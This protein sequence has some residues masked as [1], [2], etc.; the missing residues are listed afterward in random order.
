MAISQATPAAS[1]H[2]TI[3]KDFERSRSTR[4]RSDVRP[5]DQT[6]SSRG[7]PPCARSCQSRV[8]LV[9]GRAARRGSGPLRGGT[10]AW[11]HRSTRRPSR[12]CM[13]R[14]AASRCTSAGSSS[15]R[16]PRVPV[17]TTSGTC[18]SD[19]L[20]AGDLAPLPQAPAAD[21]SRPRGSTSGSPTPSSTSSTTSATARCPK[22]GRVRE[23]LD[24]CSRLHS[25]RLGRERPLWEAHVIEG[26]R[27]GRVALY[28]KIHHGLVD[29]VSAMRLMQ[30]VLSTDPDLRD[31]PPPWGGADRAVPGRRPASEPT[32]L[33]EVPIAALRTALG[34]TAEAAGL[35]A[36]LIRTLERGRAQR[37]VG[38]VAATPRGRCST[39][40]SPDRVAS[41]RRTGR[42]SGCGPSAR[43][44]A[45]RSTTS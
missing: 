20:A 36:A 11:S 42:S 45:R 25:T 18:T 8:T 13:P 17:A 1:A 23:L 41:P 30:S 14:T 9:A 21:R 3:A 35:P 38:A 7:S 4:A 33:S 26:L 19:V 2:C 24:L 29:G 27:D 12:S 6:R 39:R 34:I 10:P 5:R 16:S 44:P 28:T 15:S 43:P 31:M 32:P 40:G 37:D 22:P